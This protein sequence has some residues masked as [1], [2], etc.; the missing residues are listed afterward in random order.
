MR[1][2]LQC[3]SQLPRWERLCVKVS[4][5]QGRDEDDDDHRWGKISVESVRHSLYFLDLAQRVPGDDQYAAAL[6]HL[7]YARTLGIGES[8]PSPPSVHADIR[9]CR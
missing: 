1:C 6:L 5:L 3:W 7:F 8:M 9:A 2:V 4:Q